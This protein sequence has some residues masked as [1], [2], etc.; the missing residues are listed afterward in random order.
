MQTRNESERPGSGEGPVSDVWVRLRAVRSVDGR[1]IDF[2]CMDGSPERVQQ[3]VLRAPTRAGAAA[4]GRGALGR[5]VQP[6]PD[7]RTGGGAASPGDGAF[8][9]RHAGG[10]HHHHGARVPVRGGLTL[11]LEDFTQRAVGRGGPA[12]GS[13]SAARRHRGHHGRGLR[14]G[15]RGALRPGEHRG[16]AGV[17]PLRE[18]RARADGRGADG[19]QGAK[20]DGGARSGGVRVGADRHLRGRGRRAGFGCIWQSTKGMLQQPD[21]TV[22]GLFG[23]S[24][25]ITARKRQEE[26][27]EQESRFRE[28]FIGVLGHDLGNPLAAIRLSSAALLARPTLTPDG[29]APLAAHRRERRADGAAG[30]AAPGLHPGPHGRRHPPAPSGHVPGGG[31]PPHHLR[32]GAG[33]PGHG[34]STWRCPGAA[35]ASGTR[36]G[37]RRCSPTWWPMPSR[38]ALRAR[39]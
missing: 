14:E 36:S 3:G 25:D 23:I 2:E 10:H 22:Y 28:R 27:R 33:P 6:L 1:I 8:R 9:A 29:A 21:G 39:P 31:V 19:A 18:G 13:G 24:R 35:R 32:A 34:T 4:A 5:R 12:P 15:P 20:G 11:F 37:W 26:E 38:T 30:E 16:R 17:W 7:V